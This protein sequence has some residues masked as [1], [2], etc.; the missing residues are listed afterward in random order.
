MSVVVR[1]AILDRLS[2]GLESVTAG[3]ADTALEAARDRGVAV[4]VSAHD[5]DGTPDE[6]E[7][8]ETLS[9]ACE[10]ADRGKLAVTAET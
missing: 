1:A 6:I 2:A 4:V 8:L 3:D 5:F 9:D 10:R 7:L